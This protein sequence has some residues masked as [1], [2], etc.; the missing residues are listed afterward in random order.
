M[1]LLGL[2]TF[3]V[4]EGHRLFQSRELKGVGT[5]TRSEGE[6]SGFGFLLGTKADFGNAS[7]CFCETESKQEYLPP[8]VLRNSL[9]ST[10]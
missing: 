7:G 9:D 3:G 2:E 1:L 5:R 6:G 8:L 4:G 10:S